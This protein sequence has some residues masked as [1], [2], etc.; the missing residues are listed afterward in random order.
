MLRDIE[1]RNDVIGSRGQFFGISPPQHRPGQFLGQE[2]IDARGFEPQFPRQSHEVAIAAA[3]VKH[4]HSRRG[5]PPSPKAHAGRKLS[6]RADA[7]GGPYGWSGGEVHVCAS[8]DARN[9]TLLRMTI[10]EDKGA[11]LAPQNP[12]LG[13][14]CV[15]IEERARGL[16]RRTA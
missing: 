6:L 3:N 16:R 13:A 1:N 7:L 5:T 11:L 14:E 10:L 2:G 8:I 15:R 9:R 12:A 4:A